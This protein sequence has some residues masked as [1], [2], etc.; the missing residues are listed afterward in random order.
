LVFA[1]LLEKFGYASQLVDK[2]ANVNFEDDDGLTIFDKLQ[3]KTEVLTWLFNNG[4]DLD[5]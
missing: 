2:G 4:M 5:Y 3:H 1:L